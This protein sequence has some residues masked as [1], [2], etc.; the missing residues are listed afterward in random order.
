MQTNFCV[1]FMTNML[2]MRFLTSLQAIAQICLELKWKCVIWQPGTTNTEGN[3]NICFGYTWFGIFMSRVFIH[4]Q[5]LLSKKFGA[6][7]ELGS[8][9]VKCLTWLKIHQGIYSSS[10]WRSMAV[11]RRTSDWV[12]HP[13]CHMR[14]ANASKLKRCLLSSV[15][16]SRKHSSAFPR[17]LGL[18]FSFVWKTHHHE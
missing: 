10:G 13:R 14:H 15:S 18:P 7:V 4:L 16:A 2:Y 12:R 5:Y 8:Q 3:L 17:S 9:F 11:R 6:T 1:L